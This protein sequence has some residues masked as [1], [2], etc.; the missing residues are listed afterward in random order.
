VKG[1]TRVAKGSYCLTAGVLALA[2]SLLSATI[3]AA[4]EEETVPGSS[5]MLAAVPTHTPQASSAISAS[6]RSTV[7]ASAPVEQ[8]TGVALPP[9]RG[10][11]AAES[12][13]GNGTRIFRGDPLVAPPV[14]AEESPH[15]LHFLPD[16]A[17]WLMAGSSQV[18]DFP[19]RLK[20]V[21]IASSKIADIQ[22][23]SPYQ[24]NL[25]GHHP[26]FTTL[27]VWDQLGHYEQRQVRVDLGGKQ[28]VLLNCIVAQLDRGKIENQ[29]INF[30]RPCEIRGCPWW[31]C[32]EW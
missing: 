24:I 13:I 17:I 28:Q 19:Y 10:Q 22:V 2:S 15:G 29:G 25:I 14:E 27:I 5:S 23:I 9:L 32:P 16:D 8:A 21:S 18:F 30:R 20:R 4:I 11:T 31:A 7:A 26:G 12:T 3:V 1:E 6:P